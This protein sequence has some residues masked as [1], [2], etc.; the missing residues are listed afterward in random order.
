LATDFDVSTHCTSGLIGCSPG[1]T[2]RSAT[3]VSTTGGNTNWGLS[4][5][6][7]VYG[8]RT[9]QTVTAGSAPSFS[10][11]F[12][13]NNRM[14]GYSYDANGNQLTTPDG[15]VLEYDRD[16]RMTIW[17]RG[18]AGETY[19]YHPSGW[20]VNKETASS[21]TLYLHGPGGQ[22]LSACPVVN[23]VRGTCS[24]PVYF[25]GRLL[26]DGQGN[27]V[28]TDRL[29]STRAVN[30]VPRNYYPFGEEIGTPT[31]NNTYKFASTYRDSTTGLDYA[32]NRYYASGMGRF[33]TADPLADKSRPEPGLDANEP[34]DAHWDP[35]AELR[36][37]VSALRAVT[38][39]RALFTAGSRTGQGTYSGHMRDPQSLNRF[40]YTA[41]DPV[42]RVDPTGQS[43]CSPGAAVR[44]SKGNLIGYDAGDCVGDDEY[45]RDPGAYPGYVYFNDVQNITVGP[46]P[47]LD[48]DTCGWI[49]A[50]A[51]YFAVAAGPGGPAAPFLA[52]VSFGLSLAY[53]LGCY[54]ILD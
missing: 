32:M 27:R 50:G 3:A 38:D 23:G 33:L 24:E 54:P 53:W 46:E 12:D 49:T 18:G 7:D 42:N 21:D 41:G 36:R 30:G 31:A 35:V 8:N 4:F 19:H 29:G 5:G 52:G 6:Y 45:N 51:V 2:L 16:N 1:L 10:A 40:T 28:L 9:A 15:A 37:G 13:N 26:Y 34:E 22:L 25:A 48:R 17:A 20:R 14:V 44:D 11:A 47:V 43:Y 39:P